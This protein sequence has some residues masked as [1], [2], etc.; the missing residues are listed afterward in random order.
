MQGYLYFMKKDEGEY[1]EKCLMPHLYNPCQ[2]EFRPIFS[3]HYYITYFLCF[4]AVDNQKTFLFQQRN[5]LPVHV[6]LDRVYCILLYVPFIS[7]KSS[8]TCIYIILK[9][10]LLFFL[11]QWN[12]YAYRGTVLM[13]CCPKPNSWKCIP[14]FFRREIQTSF[15][16][17]FS[18]PLTETIV[19]KLTLRNSCSPSTSHPVGIPRASSTG[20]LLCMT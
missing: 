9:Q 10:N 6:R 1:S 11:N 15:A 4:Y 16:T 2:W 12:S 3:L 5:C 7:I 13:G 17:M 19:V 14:H 18:D 8:Y 20:P